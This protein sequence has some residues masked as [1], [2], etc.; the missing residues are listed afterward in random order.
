VEQAPLSRQIVRSFVVTIMLFLFFL[1]TLG[2]NAGSIPAT[3]DNQSTSDACNDINNCRKLSSII[4]SCLSTIFL[5]TWVAIH[6]D[7]PEPVN[8]EGMTFWQRCR[9]GLRNVLTNKLPPFIL[10]LLAPEYI[11]TWAVEQRAC[12]DQLVKDNGTSRSFMVS[13]LMLR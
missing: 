11:L 1:H 5:C 3:N 12:A 4:W 7:I 10:A 6:L 2:A 13:G 8:V 9:L